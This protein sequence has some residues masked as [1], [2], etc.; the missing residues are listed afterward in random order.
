V[1]G[2]GACGGDGFESGVDA[3]GSK[4]TA[5]V[6]PDRLGAQV[7]LGGDLL[8]RVALFQKPK[9]L[10]LAGGEM[11]RRRCEALVEASLEQP[12]DADDAFAVHQRHRA[13]LH[14][15]PRAGGREQ[16][17]GRVGGGG[18]AEHLPGE[19][20]AGAAAVFG[21]DDGCEVT[22]AN[23]ADKLLGCRV[24]PPDDSCFVEDVARDADVLESLLD[25]A[26]D[27][28]AG[29]HDGSVADLARRW[30]W[31]REWKN[32]EWFR[33]LGSAPVGERNERLDPFVSSTAPTPVSTVAYASLVAG[34]PRG[35]QGGGATL[36]GVMAAPLRRRGPARA[37]ALRERPD[38]RWRVSRAALPMSN[39]RRPHHQIDVDIDG[40]D[41]ESPPG[42]D[43]HVLSRATATRSGAG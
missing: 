28:Q 14:G 3:E 36:W 2:C 6:V 15:H 35:K 7:E 25:V 21:C 4:E 31:G 13:D 10:D 22:T 32:D 9:H 20:L 41:G 38:P 23:V 8:G 39:E 5:D 34:V 24:D 43:F 12:E 37:R 30:S 29:G 17:A 16:D 19:Q 11:R 27:F 26:A 33:L 18:G 42:A 40:R 1:S